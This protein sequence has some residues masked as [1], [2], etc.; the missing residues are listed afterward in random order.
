[1]KFAIV[2]SV[3][4]TGFGPIVFR[5]NLEENI[6]KVKKL[7]YDAVELAVKNP[8]KVKV[9]K[10]KSLLQKN[11]LD[12]ITLGT[13]QIYFDDGLSF[14]DM[15]R[16]IRLKALDRIK[17]IIDLAYNFNASVIIGLIRGKV[18]NKSEDFKSQLEQAEKN[19]SEC[20]QECLVYS[21]KYST[22]F[23]LEPINRYETNIFNRLGEVVTFLEKYKNKLDPARVGV[24]ADTF[25][26]NIEESV[27]EESFSKYIKYIKHIHFADSNRWAPGFGH[28][29]FVK[30]Y[31][32]L[33]NNKYN[34]FI[35]FEILPMPQAEVAAKKAL[36]FVKRLELL[37]GHIG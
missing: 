32:I 3:S 8:D 18:D 16:N 28:I 11:N 14:S 33:K 30:I 13:G 7:G 9:D 21:E 6:I 35:S 25:H 12:A 17:K 27:M 20:L 34:N 23:L 31:K 19:I 4:K 36:E 1:M 2:V 24:L 15:A 26:M 37:S 29:D 5:E 10:V 22:N